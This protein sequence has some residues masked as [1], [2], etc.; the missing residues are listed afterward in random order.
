MS[1]RRSRQRDADDEGDE[2]SEAESDRFI[3]KIAQYLQGFIGE[4]GW[5]EEMVRKAFDDSVKNMPKGRARRAL[6]A[7]FDEFADKL[8]DTIYRR[9]GPSIELSKEERKIEKWRK[10]PTTEWWALEQPPL[11]KFESASLDEL[12]VELDLSLKRTSFDIP[13]YVFMKAM[14]ISHMKPA[15]IAHC[16]E[17]RE[18][19]LRR[20]IDIARA[21]VTAFDGEPKKTQEKYDSVNH[22]IGRIAGATSIRR[23]MQ[24]ARVETAKMAAEIVL[25]RH[26]FRKIALGD[27]GL[28]LPEHEVGV[29]ASHDGTILLGNYRGDFAAL[30]AERLPEVEDEIVALFGENDLPLFECA[31][32][33]GGF[34]PEFEKDAKK[35]GMLFGMLDI[36][37]TDLKAVAKNAGPSLLRRP[38]K[39]AF[40][41]NKE[42]NDYDMEAY[43]R[44]PV[45]MSNESITENM[46]DRADFV[47]TDFLHE[48]L[49][50]TG[51]DDDE[52]SGPGQV[53]LYF[54]VIRVARAYIKLLNA[55]NKRKRS[56]AV[57]RYMSIAP[58]PEVLLMH[59][60]DSC[61]IDNT[62]AR[63]TSVELVVASSN[64]LQTI[65]NEW[66][67]MR[68]LFKSA[69]Q[70]EGGFFIDVNREIGE[71][72]KITFERSA[73]RYGEN[74]DDG[75]DEE[76]EAE[77]MNMLDKLEGPDA[78]S[79]EDDDED[80]DE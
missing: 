75:V 63:A 11:E 16:E 57:A 29:T 26:D 70:S 31:L 52:T 42:E 37:S 54:A 14:E 65:L 46:F 74:E 10:D 12:C 4:K 19:A 7:R 21:T 8:C 24:G 58:A 30:L 2:I 43:A 40:D 5:S 61:G 76:T 55:R 45:R 64:A 6:R 25:L 72:A 68:A 22:L 17:T 33:L 1:D 53:K 27:D 36:D 69:A 50:L 3:V 32:G 80:D 47:D 78:L 73:P 41:L 79:E 48:A 51:K 23:V 77:L 9:N 18:K 66:N 62:D 67:E 44:M 34:H 28:G 60:P 38:P 49:S 71:T 39:A 20:I 56:S 59:V 15:D 35:K 13:A